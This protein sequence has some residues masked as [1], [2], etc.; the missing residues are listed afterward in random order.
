MNLFTISIG[1][2]AAIFISSIEAG[3]NDI[4]LMWT[5]HVE[6]NCRDIIQYEIEVLYLGPCDANTF[7]VKKI[8]ITNSSSTDYHVHDLEDS[9]NYEVTI[10]VVL[11]DG[12][13]NSTTAS[14]TTL[15]ELGKI[16]IQCCC[17]LFFY[18]GYYT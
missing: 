16:M 3:S 6:P 18:L 4:T 1:Q 10:T 8:N 2:T 5:T 9:S 15:G 7:N 14:I 17:C 13:L 12:K 11:G